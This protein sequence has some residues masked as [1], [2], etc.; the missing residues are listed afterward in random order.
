MAESLDDIEE[1]AETAG[2]AMQEI[3]SYIGDQTYVA[4]ARVRFPRSYVRNTANIYATLPQ[5]GDNTKRRNL[6][7]QLMRADVCRWLLTRTDVWGQIESVVV[8]EFICILAYGVEFFVKSRTYKQV[9]RQNKFS[10]HTQ[11]LVD[12]GIIDGALKDDLDWM[13]DIRTHEHLD[14]TDELRHCTHG[15]NDFN[16]AVGVWNNFRQALHEDI[17]RQ[18]E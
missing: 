3:Q 5:L 15:R 7:Y 1:L 17:V 12:K 16:R 11:W 13:W 2:A 18:F 14:A 9:R 4:E 6:A 8:L 10:T